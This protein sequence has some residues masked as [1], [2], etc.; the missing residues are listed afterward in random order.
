MGI[1]SF[2]VSPTPSHGDKILIPWISQ[3]FSVIS[4]TSRR[5]IASR[6]KCPTGPN[7]P[8]SPIVVYEVKQR[9]GNSPNCRIGD[10][11]VLQRVSASFL[12]WFT[13]LRQTALTKTEQW[14]RPW[15]SPFQYMRMRSSA[16]LDNM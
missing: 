4:F 12:S 8:L 2:A 10:P 6:S 1:G 11:D 16:L 7:T 5:V 9:Y 15:R 14:H 3:K 13:S